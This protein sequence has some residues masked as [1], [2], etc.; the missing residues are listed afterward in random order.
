L[1]RLAVFLF[2]HPAAASDNQQNAQASG[3]DGGN[4]ANEVHILL[5]ISQLMAQGS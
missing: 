2:A 1:T 4:D 5:L 3:D